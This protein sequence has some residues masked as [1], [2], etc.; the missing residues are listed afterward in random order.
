MM[1][2]DAE[3][4]T[5]PIAVHDD[6]DDPP[7][8]PLPVMGPLPAGVV[9]SERAAGTLRQY[10]DRH[11]LSRHRIFHC[12]DLDLED[13][14]RHLEALGET[15]AWEPIDAA[16][17]GGEPM[18]VLT[19]GSSGGKIWT[20][21]ILR[22]KRHDIVLAR[23]YWVDEHGVFR[24]LWLGA[25][26]TA[27]NY[28]RLRDAVR[29]HRRVRGGKVWQIVRDG[30]SEPERI[31]RE[32]L[33]DDELILSPQLSAQLQKDVIRFFSDEVAALYKGLKVPYRR[34]VLLHGPPG[35]GKTSLIRMIGAAL[36]EVPMLV[37]RPSVRF[38]ADAL[39]TVIKR[40]SSQAPA[41]LIIEDLDWLLKQLNVSAFLNALD[42]ID[43]TAAGGSGGLLLIAT[44]NHPDQLDPAINNRPG[45]FDVV[46]EI[47]CPD[48]ALRLALLTNR[49]PHMG[50][51]T[52]QR[53][54][55][56]T[57]GLSFAHL[58]E[59]L[60][61]SGLTAIHSGRNQRSPED[62]LRGGVGTGDQRSG[63]ARIPRKAGY[64]VW[65]DA[66]QIP[67]RFP[68]L[69]SNQFIDAPGK[70]SGVFDR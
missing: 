43:I 49:L 58:Q 17:A 23:W 66:A 42:G 69:A 63:S 28:I 15:A 20:A 22:L 1:I 34:G 33:Y 56:M 46:L 36:A 13:V 65:A 16:T 50:T 7:R 47:P 24:Q 8:Q 31:T 57:E 5:P 12:T 18:A 38:N 64:A 2:F 40:W 41:G 6:D 27:E 60:R 37:L 59:I 35:N 39:H 53:V 14:E 32:P 70:C 67:M 51:A 44:T 68:R 29:S 62:L 11:E 48:R 21:G 3:I 45:R 26:T 25:A 30:W 10:L 52:L 4:Q 61:S 55:D 9:M 19:H 54:A